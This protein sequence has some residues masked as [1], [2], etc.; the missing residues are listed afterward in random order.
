M[1]KLLLSTMLICLSFTIK[2]QVFTTNTTPIGM[3]HNLLFNATSRYKVTPSGNAT[4]NLNTL[5][6]GKLAPSYTATAPTTESPTVI[7]IEN[8]PSTH[9]QTGAWVGWTTRY[10]QAIRFKIEGYNS[11]NNANEWVTFADFSNQDYT[12]GRSF[13]TKIPVNGTYTKL[14]FSFYK[15]SG[16]NG[17]LGVSEL[18]FLHP[19]VV[20][21]YEGLYASENDLNWKKEGSNIYFKS[22][23]VGIGTT[24]ASVPLDVNGSVKFNKNNSNYTSIQLGHDVNDKIFADNASN[25]YYGGGYFF[26]VTPDPS[27]NISENYIDVIMITD[28]GNVGIGARDTKGYKLA[29]AG[30]IVAEE[31][32]IQLESNWPDYVFEKEYELPTLPEVEKYIQEKGHLQNIPSAKEVKDNN[33]IELGKMNSKLLQKI[34]ELTLYTIQQQ[35][36]LNTTKEKNT[37]LEARLLKL[38]KIILKLE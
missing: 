9:T 35:K 28:K 5:F 12:G 38:E 17:R 30:N 22:G 37:T 33:G 20:V 4:L 24:T 19:E 16:S 7:L 13:N 15:A 3:E 6:D 21:P 23:N 1:K 26:R 36:E 2:A 25:K 32:K 27:L 10:W 31:V 8:L 29:V 18:F 11:Y 34:E 14:R